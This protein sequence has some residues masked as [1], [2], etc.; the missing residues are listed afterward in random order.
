MSSKTEESTKQA[1]GGS[2]S[3]P[4]SEGD[5]ESLEYIETEPV[6]TYTRMKNDVN[7]IV[8]A[9]SLSCIRSNHKVMNSIRWPNFT[10][11]NIFH[12]IKLK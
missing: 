1:V 4:E 2:A 8:Q 12:Y 9:D 3:Q 10:I 5:D 6:L 11:I 7:E